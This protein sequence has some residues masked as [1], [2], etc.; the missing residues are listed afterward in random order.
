MASPG[1]VRENPASR[2]CALFSHNEKQKTKILLLVVSVVPVVA[3][4]SFSLLSVLSMVNP[5]QPQPKDR[6]LGWSEA[7]TQLSRKSPGVGK[8]TPGGIRFCVLRRVAPER[9][10]GE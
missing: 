3:K 8:S 10:Q 1:G 5:P 9:W 6:R 4:N 2:A 7:E